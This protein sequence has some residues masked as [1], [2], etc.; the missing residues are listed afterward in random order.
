MR[1]MTYPVEQGRDITDFGSSGVKFCP[2][3]R[4]GRGGVAVMHVAAGGEIGRHPAT[5][6][7]L[8][9]VVAGRGSVC[10]HDGVWEPIATGKAAF[11]AAGEEHT[12]RADEPLV[13]V[14]IEVS[15]ETVANHPAS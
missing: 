12:T 1:I 15:Q 13:A 2:L 6:D 4:I 10:G 3:T 7:Q 5:V 8:F 14:V 9:V 11:W